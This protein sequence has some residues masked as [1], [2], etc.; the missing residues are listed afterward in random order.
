[1]VITN[2]RTFTLGYTPNKSSDVKIVLE[3]KKGNK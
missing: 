2:V 3:S 1:M